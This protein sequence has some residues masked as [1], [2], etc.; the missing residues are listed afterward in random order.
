MHTIHHTQAYN[1]PY[2]GVPYTIYRHTIYHTQQHTQAYSTPYTGIQYTIHRH[3][4]HQPQAYNTPYT[5][6]QYAI[7]RYTIHCGYSSVDMVFNINDWCYVLHR[8]MQV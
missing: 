7:H 3:T 1:T 2:T 5:G 4:I 8:T 6:I